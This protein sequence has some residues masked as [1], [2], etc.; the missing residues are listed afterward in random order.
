M[1]LQQEESPC[2]KAEFKVK[3]LG[4]KFQI[5]KKLL[6]ILKK[7][8]EINCEEELCFI[9]YFINKKTNYVQKILVKFWNKQSKFKKI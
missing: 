4:N 8:L 3:K 6:E 9:E 5:E 1:N 7:D 2:Y